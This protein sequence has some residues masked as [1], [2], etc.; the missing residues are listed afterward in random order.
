MYDVLASSLA[1]ASLDEV[2]S[3]TKIELVQSYPAN[4]FSKQIFHDHDLIFNCETTLW[5]LCSF[6]PVLCHCG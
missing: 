2:V 6:I 4:C 1:A 5:D 3:S